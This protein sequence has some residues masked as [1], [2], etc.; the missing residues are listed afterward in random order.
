MDV[1][2]DV[3]EMR[4]AVDDFRRAVKEF[5][6]VVTTLDE[7]LAVSMQVADDMITRWKEVEKGRLPDGWEIHQ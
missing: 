3:S 1:E 4:M 5:K 2:L 7:M 6:Q